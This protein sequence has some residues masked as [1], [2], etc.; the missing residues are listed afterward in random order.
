MRRP[1]P[2]LPL[3]PKL[4]KQFA[5]VTL[6]V[7]GLV[8]LLANGEAAKMQAEVQAREAR[9]ELLASEA[10]RLGT[11]KV[12]ASMKVKT[13]MGGWGSDT[14][15]E[16][17]GEGSVDPGSGGGASIPGQ[18]TVFAPHMGPKLPPNLPSVPGANVT[19][20]GQVATDLTGPLGDAARAKEKGKAGYMYRP[21]AK[22]IEQIKAASRERTG[23]SDADEQ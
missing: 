4:L 15:G 13:Q 11:R 22:Q 3:S 7:T 1:A 14:G 17:G 20:K 2:Q 21:D 12:A 19:V 9:N 8:A 18:K 5:G 23:G 10:E 16:G 6:V